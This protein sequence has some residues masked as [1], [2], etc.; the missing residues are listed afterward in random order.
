MTGNTYP[1]QLVTKVAADDPDH[2]ENGTVV[3]SLAEENELFQVDQLSGDVRL[4][5]SLGEDVSGIRMLPV[6]A[7]DQG[8]PALTSTCLLLVQLNGEK[9]LLQFTE[10]IYEV[11]LP[12][13]GKTGAEHMSIIQMF[14]GF[15]ECTHQIQFHFCN[16][17][18]RYAHWSTQNYS[19]YALVSWQSKIKCT[20][21]GNNT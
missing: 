20:N 9:P 13:N 1:G 3:F 6:L 2:R 16:F 4:K 7:V 21:T 14:G 19:S 18:L 10:Q 5:A 12:E 17:F 15:L 8:T 11:T